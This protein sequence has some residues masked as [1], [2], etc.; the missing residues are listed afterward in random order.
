[1]YC[2]G[3]AHHSGFRTLMVKRCC[4]LNLS[5]GSVWL[6]GRTND[7]AALELGVEKKIKSGS[8]VTKFESVAGKATFMFLEGSYVLH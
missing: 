5:G 1:M 4:V 8:S 7:R 2:A 6:V 3:R